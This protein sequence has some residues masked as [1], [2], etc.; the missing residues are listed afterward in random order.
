MEFSFVNLKKSD[1]IATI[2][3]NRP[4]ASNTL[5]LGIGDEIVKVFEICSHDDTVRAIV[6]TGAGKTFC[7]GGDIDL[8]NNSSDISESVDRVVI[9]LN[10]VV[11]SIRKTLKPV[12]AM[13]NGSTAGGGV[14]L[15]AA[16]DLRICGATVK[17]K[18]SYT[19]IGLVHDGGWALTIPLLIGLGKAEEL[20]L[21]DPVFGADEALKIGLVN[22]VVEDSTL[23]KVTYDI[24]ARLAKGPT[25]SF[26]M[27]KNNLNH[28]MFGFLEQQLE[29]ERRGI[30]LVSRTHDAMEG[31]TAFLEKRHSR[32][33]GN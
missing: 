15:A 21:L 18:L 16:C 27:V 19:T 7:A 26:A 20:A 9:S 25:A 8:F 12:I 30:T 24:A 5:N 29:V 33:T 22:K 32:F 31:I 28:A 17:F 11:R 13:I 14:S 1:A 4:E 6:I 10:N 3:L 23:H 2:T